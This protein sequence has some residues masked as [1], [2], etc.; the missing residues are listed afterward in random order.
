V[1]NNLAALGVGRIAPLGFCGD[2]G[3]G[4][5]LRRALAQRAGTDLARFITTDLRRTFTYGKPLVIEPE[6]VPQEL[7]R[8]D[9][10]NWTPTPRELEDEIVSG[11]EAVADSLDALIVLDQVDR[12]DTGVVTG[13]V[14]AAVERLSR[15]RDLLILADARRGLAHFPPLGYKMNL[16]ELAQ[17][18]PLSAAPSLAETQTA[19]RTIALRTS[20]AAFVTLAERG[21]VGAAPDGAVHHAAALPVR[22]PID[23]VGAG[24]AVTAN[25]AVSLTAGASL[26]DALSIAMAAASL[27]I[28]QLGTTGAASAAEIGTLLVSSV[29]G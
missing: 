19:C 14:L 24:D 18:T 5:E 29:V 16:R 7:D 17:M 11:L 9:I 22:G 20:R 26:P 27:V 28:H 6:R 15:R 4:Y 10:K 23:I 21:I 12:A 1:L 13:R 8:L 25:L 2:D 3:E